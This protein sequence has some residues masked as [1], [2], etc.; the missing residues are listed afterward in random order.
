[1]D[2]EK[3]PVAKKDNIVLRLIEGIIVILFLGVVCFGFLIIAMFIMN[4]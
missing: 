1:M 4:R 2:D 3:K